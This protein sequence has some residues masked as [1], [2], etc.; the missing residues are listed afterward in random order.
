[1]KCPE[2]KPEC[3][4]CISKD[5]KC[6]YPRR[7]VRGDD[8]LGTIE[9]IP[10]EPNPTPFSVQDM[11]FFHH[12]LLVAHPYLPLGCDDAWVAS[13]PLLSH[14]YEFVMHAILGLGAAHLS[15][16]RPNGD[17]I[18]AANAI[19]HRGKAL[20]GMQGI[21]TKQDLS[22]RELD[23]L[24]ATCYALTM[25]SGYMF[26]A[27][28]DFVIFIRGCVLVTYKI[29]QKNAADSVFP[30]E[31]T[32]RR[33]RFVPESTGPLMVD[34]TLLQSGIES[35]QSLTPLLEDEVHIHFRKCISDTLIA[36]RDSSK[37]AFLAYEKNYSAWYDISHA[38]FS[39]FIS[40][41][42]TT[43]LILFAYLIATETIM[44][45]TLSSVLPERA[46]VPEVTLY[47]SQWVDVIY[48]KLPPHLV[49][50]IRWPLEAIYCCGTQHNIFSLEVGKSLQRTFLG[51]VKGYDDGGMALPI[52]TKISNKPE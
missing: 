42:N 39:R 23:A 15:I 31:K 1:M 37:D 18:T 25:Q 20:K 4:N 41:D 10:V 9:S 36:V 51:Y 8:G 24:L 11:G 34:P 27:L 2:T 6:E 22:S 48:R 33:T 3:E 28:T 43:T 12:Y 32:A 16:I 30:W 19:E 29:E 14:Q 38:Q 40:P 17:P 13:I 47:Q 44:I 52:Y 35:L 21:M 5:L 7:R 26:D 46:R 45:P 50:Y 49:Q